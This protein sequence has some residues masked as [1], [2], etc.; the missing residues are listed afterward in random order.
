M[1][2]AKF[3]KLQLGSRCMTPED[4]I[5]Y[6]AAI[7]GLGGPAVGVLITLFALIAG[8]WQEPF[9]LA[10]FTV[11]LIIFLALCFLAGGYFLLEKSAWSFYAAIA[12][13]LL[14]I[15]TLIGIPLAAVVLY[16]L[17]DKEVQKRFA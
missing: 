8:K 2:V 5:N 11:L 1:S 12:L 7:L 14:L 15:L 16:F 6:S 17:F 4:K 13:S 10:L 3:F 9:V